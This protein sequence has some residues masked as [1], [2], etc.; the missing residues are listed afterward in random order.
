[1]FEIRTS[2]VKQETLNELYGGKK[3]KTTSH[4]LNTHHLQHT[5]TQT[6]THSGVINVVSQSLLGAADENQGPLLFYLRLYLTLTRSICPESLDVQILQ[7]N[8]KHL[9]QEMR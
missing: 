1:M 6:H 8:E 9:S 2:T 4:L 3:K 7:R 5:H